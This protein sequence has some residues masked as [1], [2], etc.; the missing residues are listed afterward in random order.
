MQSFR[1]RG[2]GHFLQA[3]VPRQTIATVK[4]CHSSLL[5]STS[6]T[7]RIHY[8][9]YLRNLISFFSWGNIFLYDKCPG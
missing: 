7:P 3:N 6:L 9:Y 8:F 4:H 1:E 5:E 2:K